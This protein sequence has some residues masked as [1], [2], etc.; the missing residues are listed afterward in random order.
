MRSEQPNLNRKHY[1]QNE[2]LMDFL[3]EVVETAPEL[4]QEGDSPKLKRQRYVMPVFV[5]F[6]LR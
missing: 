5:C 6:P 3:Q 1:V 2:P 4:G